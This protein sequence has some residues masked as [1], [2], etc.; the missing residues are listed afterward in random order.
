[1]LAVAEVDMSPIVW[2]DTDPTQPGW[3]RVTVTMVVN[4]G[5]PPS[6]LRPASV[7]RELLRSMQ[8]S[9]FKSRS[10]CS[11]TPVTAVSR[12]TRVGCVYR[13][14]FPPEQLAEAAYDLASAYMSLDRYA[15]TTRGG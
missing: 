5:S 4:G 7:T 1:M 14:E 15:G 2:P 12:K 3:L 11:P 6:S 10:W 8:I 13:P 9:E